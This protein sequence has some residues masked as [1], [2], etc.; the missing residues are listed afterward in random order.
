[1]KANAIADKSIN[2]VSEATEYMA[3]DLE[4]FTKVVTEDASTVY[5]AVAEATYQSI[6]DYAGEDIANDAVEIKSTA[7]S[8]LGTGLKTLVSVTEQIL[9]DSEDEESEPEVQL[10]HIESLAKLQNENST[11]T[12]EVEHEGFKEWLDKFIADIDKKKE[13]ISELLIEQPKVRRKYNELVPK[14]VLHNNFWAR[15]LF[16]TQLL[17]QKFATSDQ[18][19]EKAQAESNDKV[20]TDAEVAVTEKLEDPEILAQSQPE[21]KIEK[22]KDNKEEKT[23][24]DENSDLNTATKED[25]QVDE[26]P[27][28]KQTDEPEAEP[29][30]VVENKKTAPESKPE[31]KSSKKKKKKNKGKK[32]PEPPKEV[33]PDVAKQPE[34][35]PKP[36]EP[37]QVVNQSEQEPEVVTRQ[38]D[39]QENVVQSVEPVNEPSSDDSIVKVDKKDDKSDIDD[40]EDDLD[41]ENVDITDV[42]LDDEDWEM[43][44]IET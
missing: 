27:D 31:S 26:Q 42:N 40:W 17:E 30:R 34:P 14:D 37:T 21:H 41:I 23:Q 3:K 11:Y 44:D 16:R 35:E 36:V 5:T 10:T 24:P 38:E 4:E 12:T 29:A 2:L 9:L 7:V 20:E 22:P 8:L 6:N 15:Y 19:E 18:E 1:V 33:E 32:S 28:K 25:E 43:S 13:E 39:K